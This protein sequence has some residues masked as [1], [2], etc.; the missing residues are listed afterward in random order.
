V[1]G[2]TWAGSVSWI[3][4]PPLPAVLTRPPPAFGPCDR[5]ARAH[6]RSLSSSPANRAD[7]NAHAADQ[8]G[9]VTDVLAASVGIK[10]REI[11]RAANPFQT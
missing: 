2:R 7:Q 8:F 11:N 9:K 6:A 3:F 4:M 5:W 1:Y 10:T